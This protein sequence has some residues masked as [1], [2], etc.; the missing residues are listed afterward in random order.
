MYDPSNSAGGKLSALH[1]PAGARRSF[2]PRLTLA[3]AA[4]CCAAVTTGAVLWGERYADHEVEARESLIGHDMVESLDRMLTNVRT[5]RRDA[6]LEMV[7]QNC[8]DIAL[9]LAELETYVQ[10]VRGI[11]LVDHHQLYCSSALGPLS[12]PLAS[13]VPRG[14]PGSHGVI[15]NLLAGTPFQPG[16]PVISMYEPSGDGKGVEYTIEGVYVTDTLAHGIRYGAQQVILSMP[17]SGVLTDKGDF[18]PSIK[19]PTDVGT[20]VYS[21]QWP[22]S[23]AVLASATLATEMHW[24][25]GLLFGAL[26]ILFD[27]L[28]VALALL[29]LAPHRQ[30]LAA[31]R[32]G[33]RLGQLHVVYQP[34]VEIATRQIVGVE[35]LI[36][37]T[38]PRWGSVSPSVFMAQVERS[39]L[40]SRVTRFAL[41]SAAADIAQKTTI[42]PLRVAVN[43][44]PLDL[45]RKDFVADVLA[46]NDTLP[47]GVTLVLELTERFLLEKQPRTQAIFDVLKA[48]GVQFAIDDFGTQHSNLDLLGRFPFDYVKIDGQFVRQV[49]RGGAALIRA[50]AA[51]AKHYGMEIIAEGVESEAQHAALRELGIP[52]GQGFLYQRPTSARELHVEP[53]PGMAATRP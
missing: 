5:Q 53:E 11:N 38:H 20:R 19:T 32:R 4:L 33:L 7:G 12:M 15:V 13:Y 24:R 10:Y 42:R 21:T 18:V 28:I 50:I 14:T 45:Q 17:G 34:V 29:A 26:A 52:F 51:V 41:H 9:P 46:V 36:R 22:F 8:R 31:V 37:W 49:D 2:A 35:A 43:I 27:L 16:T 23:V 6:L 47:P 1:G 39:P 48:R 30:L 25:Y 40:I 44:A 3:I